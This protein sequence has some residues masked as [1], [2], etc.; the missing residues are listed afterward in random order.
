MGGKILLLLMEKIGLPRVRSV[1]FWRAMEMVLTL[2][3]TLTIGFGQSKVVCLTR[4]LGGPVAR[5]AHSLKRL[6]TTCRVFS[7]SFTGKAW[8][9]RK[10]FKS[11]LSATPMHVRTSWCVRKKME[12][13]VG[14]HALALNPVHL[15]LWNLS[16]ERMPRVLGSKGLCRCVNFKGLAQERKIE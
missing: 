15:M 8:S 4:Q 12:G 2:L 1:V 13:G 6:F 14:E 7:G 3:C 11:T 9:K 16:F 5:F 10:Q